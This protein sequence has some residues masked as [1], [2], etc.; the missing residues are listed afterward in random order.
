MKTLA[1]GVALAI[2][3]FG[4]VGVFFPPALLWVARQSLSST[5]FYVIA[6]ARIAFGAILI[7]VAAASR[8]PKALLVLGY[9]VLI[10]GIA[11]ALT[12][13]FAI[14]RASPVIDWWTRQGSGI[15]RL[16]AA[17]VVALGSFVAYA[18]APARPLRLA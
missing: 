1:F 6:A 3:A 5:A 13:L 11:T 2:V 18:C 7:S 10:A 12:G 15:V 16:T 17:A 8:A 9:F 4:V 14:D